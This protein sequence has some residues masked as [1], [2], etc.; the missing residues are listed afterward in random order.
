MELGHWISVDRGLPKWQIQLSLHGQL[1]WCKAD[2][3][4]PLFNILSSDS[5]K[6]RSNEA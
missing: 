3:D 5:L 2:Y 6:T 4:W 1:K